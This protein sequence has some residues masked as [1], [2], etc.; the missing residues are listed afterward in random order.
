MNH[1]PVLSDTT[2]AAQ[3]ILLERYRRMTFAEKARIVRDLTRTA[4]TLA[5]AGAKQRH[6]NASEQ[7]LLLQL[8]AVR[9]GPD[10]TFRAYGWR[11]SD[12]A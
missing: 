6:P 4:D 8:A 12:D 5:L 3:R 7:E 2:P 10:L 9:L 1:R 11:A